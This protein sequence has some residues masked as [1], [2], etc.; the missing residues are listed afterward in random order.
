M[1][2]LGSRYVRFNLLSTILF[3]WILSKPAVAEEPNTAPAIDDYLSFL[4]SAN[5]YSP[6]EGAGSHGSI[7]FGLGVGASA[8]KKPENSAL[9]D[10]QLRNPDQFA[11]N[12]TTSKSD[13][14][15]I[16]RAFFHKG[17]LW[18]VDFGFGMGR[19]GDLRATTAGG[20]VQWTV[21]ESFALPA[22]AMRLKHSRLMGL[23]ST[24][25]ESTALET[26]ASY[27][28]RRLTVYGTYA[29]NR[30]NAVIRTSGESGTTI[31]LTETPASDYHATRADRSHTVGLQIQVLPPICNVAVESR[32]QSGQ[33]SL[34]AKLSLGI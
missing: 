13:Q 7:G 8:E 20:Y 1:Q 3:A 14:I 2:T 25:F 26:A 24:E 16:P 17:L 21:F 32:V 4:G 11:S 18:P 10:D 6:A 9:I 27:G 12:E 5:S 29:F 19:I 30:H 28:F 23:P 31:A 22:V 34:L 33:S 15:V